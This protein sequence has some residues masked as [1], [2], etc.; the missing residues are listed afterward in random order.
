MQQSNGAGMKN[1]SRSSTIRICKFKVWDR[2]AI[3]LSHHVNTVTTPPTSALPTIVT[4][5]PPTWWNCV[6]PVS[7]MLSHKPV[8]SSSPPPLWY[9]KLSH[10]TPK[11]VCPFVHSPCNTK[12]KLNRTGTLHSIARGHP[13]AN[14]P[15]KACVR[16]HSTHCDLHHAIKSA[17]A[18]GAP[19]LIKQH[20]D[21][22]HPKHPPFCTMPYWMPT[23]K[24]KFQL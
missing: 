19:T 3:W 10:H 13:T 22:P 2:V 18:G 6:K 11:P 20:H 12:I 14:T 4:V 8:L 16:W 15:S 24:T 7:Q 1:S 17:W 9:S 21:V 23:T 5:P